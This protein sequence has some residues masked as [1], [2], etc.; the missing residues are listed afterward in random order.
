MPF[1]LSGICKQTS[2]AT[3]GTSPRCHGKV[4]LCDTPGQTLHA[5]SYAADIAALFVEQPLPVSQAP[6]SS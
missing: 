1:F 3:S 6:G 4:V 2:R 5:H